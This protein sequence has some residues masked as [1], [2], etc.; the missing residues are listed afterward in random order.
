MSLALLSKYVAFTTDLWT[1]IQNIAYMCVTVHWLAPEWHL[2]SAI[3]QMREMGEKHTGQNISVRLAEAASEWGLADS[4]I[5]ATVHD[6]GA[7]INLAMDL[8]DA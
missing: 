8:L 7:N 3:M 5:S 4:Q 1:S 6:N 2:R